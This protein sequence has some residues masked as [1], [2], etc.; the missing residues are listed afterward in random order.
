ML[1]LN[2]LKPA[3]GSVRNRMRV[4]RG[5]GSGNGTT[6]GRGNNGHSAR[7]GTSEKTYFEGGQTPLVRRTPKKGFVSPFK[8]AY[9]V[10]NVGQL[11]TLDIQEID[12]KTLFEHGLI[13]SPDRPVK[14]L[15]GGTLTKTVTVKADAYSKSARDKL[16]MPKPVKAG[17]KAQ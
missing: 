6:A 10:V 4:G 13:G 14:I 3:A 5:Q 15:G 7:N 9:Q 16:K 8:V 2:D 12:A 1:N 11:E 17:K